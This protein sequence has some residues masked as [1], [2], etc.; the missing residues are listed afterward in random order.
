MFSLIMKQGKYS[1]FH[2]DEV[3]GLIP[4][5]PPLKGGLRNRPPIMRGVGGI[6][7]YLTVDEK[8]YNS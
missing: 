5:N 8:R 2:G 7:M 6:F 1:A 3:Q 4:L